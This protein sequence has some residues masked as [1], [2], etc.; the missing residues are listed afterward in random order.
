MRCPDKP[1]TW[2][3]AVP[4]LAELCVAELPRDSE[5]NPQGTHHIMVYVLISSCVVPDATI[6]TVV[7]HESNR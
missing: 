6:V 5:I 7:W 4:L 3:P 1:V 2:C